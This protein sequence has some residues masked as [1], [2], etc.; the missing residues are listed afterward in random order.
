MNKLTVHPRNFKFITCCLDAEKD[1]I[2]RMTEKALP[3]CSLHFFKKVDR[4]EVEK[5]L[6]YIKPRRVSHDQ[7]VRYYR[8]KYKGKRCYYIARSS[9]KYIYAE[10]A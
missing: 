1:D 7:L 3:I 6:G 9:I 2:T 10:V 5:Q 8:S 4:D